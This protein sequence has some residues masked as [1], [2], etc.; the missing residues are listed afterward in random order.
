[1]KRPTIVR[2]G[3]RALE[4]DGKPTPGVVFDDERR[5][6]DSRSGFSPNEMSDKATEIPRPQAFR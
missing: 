6:N 4:A 2:A 5:E 3:E 1:V